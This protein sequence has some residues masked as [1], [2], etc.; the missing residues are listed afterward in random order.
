VVCCAAKLKFDALSQ[1]AESGGAARS[2][3]LQQGEKRCVAM[4][5]QDKNVASRCG[6]E[7]RGA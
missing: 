7:R 4:R 2:Q 3:A 6:V 1:V 5:R